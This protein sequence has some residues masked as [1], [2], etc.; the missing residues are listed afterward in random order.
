MYSHVYKALVFSTRVTIIRDCVTIIRDC[1]TI[2]MH[3][4]VDSIT[5]VCSYTLLVGK[6][7]FETSSLKETYS[8][9][10]RNDYRIPSHVN[11]EA[12]FLINKLLDSNPSLRPNAAQILQH[13]F[14]SGGYCP[15]KLPVR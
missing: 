10:K 2:I 1:A 14:L 12:R 15:T 3:T 13:P 9:I 6:P 4:S 11:P 7:P 5:C 8:R